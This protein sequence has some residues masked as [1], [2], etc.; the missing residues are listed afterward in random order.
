M[1]IKTQLFPNLC[2]FEVSSWWC[3]L[4]DLETY[5]ICVGG[6]LIVTGVICLITKRFSKKK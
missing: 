4:T 2:S 6:A 1:V 5:F 3:P